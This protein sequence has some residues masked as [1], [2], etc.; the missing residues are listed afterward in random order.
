VGYYVGGTGA[1]DLFA[2]KI[3]TDSVAASLFEPEIPYGAWIV[4]P[5]LIGPFGAAG[6]PAKAVSMSAFALMHPFDPAFTA[7]SGDIWADYTL[8]TKTFNPLVL[9][10][11]AAGTINVTI[12]PDASQVGATVSGYVYVDTFNPFVGT[13]DEVVRIPY[14]YTVAP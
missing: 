12:A 2:K 8:G 9:A 6:A 5:A 3:G 14:S 4:S 1:P 10:S 7:D 13:G 11:G